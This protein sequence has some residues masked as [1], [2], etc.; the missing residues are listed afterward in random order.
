MPLVYK[1]SAPNDQ[2]SKFSSHTNCTFNAVPRSISKPPDCV[3]DPVSFEFNRRILSARFIVSVLI[4]V[5]VPCTVRSPVRTK[6][7]NST[8]SVV[9]T[10]CPIAIS[11]LVTVTPVPPEI[12]VLTSAALGPV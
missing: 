1:S 9:A 2:L 3:G 12:C 7:A 10:D 8:S 11:P 6:S 4:V 5:V